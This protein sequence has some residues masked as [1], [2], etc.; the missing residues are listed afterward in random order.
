MYMKQKKEFSIY[1]YQYWMQNGMTEEA[2]KAKVTD[3]QKENARKAVSKIKPENSCFKKEYWMIRKGMSEDAAIEEIRNLQSKL[4]A[5]S[6][7]YLGKTRTDEQKVKISNSM[8]KKIAN[9][10]IGKWV[11][12]FGEFNGN[13]KIEK[14]F[15]LYIKENINND[16][17]ANVP[18]DRYV[19]DIL[20]KNYIIEFYG[21]FWH[22]NPKFYEEADLIKSFNINKT[23]KELWEYDKKRIEYLKSVGYNVL[24]I[25]EEDWKKNNEECI[26]I[27]KEYYE[28][29]N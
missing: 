3:I 16:I 18:I 4:S 12:H 28:K 17:Q 8:K 11:R 13:S 26:K 14:E 6:T 1:R 19:V 5:R 22:A 29:I 24:V 20:Y 10:G 15:Y 25:W 27:I 21:D 2:A 9:I 23:A 7:K